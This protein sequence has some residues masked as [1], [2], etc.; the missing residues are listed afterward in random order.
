MA[1]RINGVC[2]FV[3]RDI[4]AAGAL[5]FLKTA[6]PPKSSDRQRRYFSLGS[7]LPFRETFFCDSPSSLPLFYH[8]PPQF[9]PESLRRFVCSCPFSPTAI[10]FSRK[11]TSV[12][13]PPLVA[14]VGW[15]EWNLFLSNLL[16]LILKN[17]WFI[18]KKLP[19]LY[20]FFWHEA[21][22]R[23]FFI[24]KSVCIR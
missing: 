13:H 16:R 20:V 10:L 17:L 23:Q 2:F 6:V 24:C 3:F 14:M 1:S 11:K 18:S 7:W 5:C 21:Q 8:S 9:R 15:G 12:G 19:I 22:N 4:S